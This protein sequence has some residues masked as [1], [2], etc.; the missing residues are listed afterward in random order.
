MAS[1]NN[2]EVE[3]IEMDLTKEKVKPNQ[4]DA[5]IMVF[6]HVPKNGQQ[7]L[8]KSMIDAVMPGGH[9]IFEVYSEAQLAYET[10]GPQSV[11]MLYNPV[12]ILQWIENYKCIHF[13]YGE[14]ARNEG[15]KHTG[16]GH[17]I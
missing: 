11:D 2:V 16:L 12:D 15:K 6:G 13:Y 3:T 4:Y 9:I 14:A 1:Q 8:M 10:G 5:A 17:V 7:F